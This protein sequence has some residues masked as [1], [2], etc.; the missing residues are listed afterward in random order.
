MKI[1]QVTKGGFLS[2]GQKGCVAV[3]QTPQF[4]CTSTYTYASQNQSTAKPTQSMLVTVCMYMYIII[5][6]FN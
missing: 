4:V 2:G 6:S 1:Q 3:R 5:F